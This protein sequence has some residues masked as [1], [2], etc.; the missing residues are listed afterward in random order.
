MSP[1][2]RVTKV[3]LFLFLQIIV[4]AHGL[5]L[6]QH[7]L[8]ATTLVYHNVT[9]WR[10]STSHNTGE[11]QLCFLHRKFWRK[12]KK[13]QKPYL[14]SCHVLSCEINQQQTSLFYVIFLHSETP[15]I[16]NLGHSSFSWFLA[17]NLGHHWLTAEKHP[18]TFRSAKRKT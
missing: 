12:I 10:C 7:L 14:L 2:T 1:V 11:L 6:W 18:E 17:L 4:A 15:W 3:L 13:I 16:W 8:Y 9:S 5:K